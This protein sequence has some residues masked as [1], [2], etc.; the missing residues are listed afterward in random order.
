[1]GDVTEMQGRMACL[2]PCTFAVYEADDGSVR[3][4]KMNT[5]LTGRVFGGTVARIM[6]GKV[7]PEETRILQDIVN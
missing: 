5:G 2:M 4:S 3:I 7:G 6:A 1:M